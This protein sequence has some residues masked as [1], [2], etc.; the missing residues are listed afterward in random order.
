MTSEPWY[1]RPDTFGKSAEQSAS[2]GSAAG[3][4]AKG[5]LKVAT[6]A[7]KGIARGAS[8][9][10][11]FVANNSWGLRLFSFISSMGLF[12]LSIIGLIGI[13]GKKEGGHSASFYLFNAYMILLS[14]LAFIAECKAEW[15][16]FHVCKLIIIL[17]LPQLSRSISVHG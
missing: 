10:S 2:G 6:F 5:A 8:V 9:V 12:S 16:G 13:I 7:G 15:K 1:N 17:S 3:S 14:M 11:D 4:A